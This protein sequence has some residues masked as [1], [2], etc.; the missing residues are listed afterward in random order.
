VNAFNSNHTE[1]LEPPTFLAR[2]VAVPFTSPMLATTRIRPAEHGAIEVVV[3]NPSGGPG[4]FI[5]D[6]PHA[7]KLRSATMH[8][9]LLFRRISQRGMPDPRTVR[10]A[11]L[12][13]AAEGL[14]GP[15]AAASAQKRIDCDQADRTRVRDVLARRLSGD[16]GSSA[17]PEE[18]IAKSL[19]IGTAHAA[20]ALREC[21]D[22]VAPIG[23]SAEDQ[24][25]RVPRMIE[26]L[27]KAG[28]A[29]HDWAGSDEAHDGDGIGITMAQALRGMAQMGR[30]FVSGLRR[31]FA[32][33]A[34]LLRQGLTD[35]ASLRERADRALWLLDGWERLALIW[36]AADSVAHRRLA[37]LEIAHGLPSIPN[38][39]FT[40]KEPSVSMVSQSLSWKVSYGGQ[41]HLST[42]A[43]MLL[44]R[45][46]EAVR[47]LSL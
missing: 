45:R 14:A 23:L 4:A 9:A 17:A 1:S 36:Q 27:N 34:T 10:D 47:A 18:I 39:A 3:P 31:W 46:N 5:T 15:E 30:G 28:E 33:P 20:I 19:N 32:D 42:A 24:V 25:S 44:V 41:A 13:I 7:A 40:W 29:L 38:E 21:C 22:V 26:M 12:A 6:W 2:G 11:A 43:C 16:A 8:D 37:V 35:P